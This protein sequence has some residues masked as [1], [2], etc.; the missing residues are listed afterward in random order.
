MKRRCIDE[1]PHAI[2]HAMKEAKQILHRTQHPTNPHSHKA[3][4][5]IMGP[6]GAHCTAQPQLQ[7][8]SGTVLPVRF[9]GFGGGMFDLIPT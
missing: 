3:I 5:C 4:V 9:D 8:A 2:E 1:M 7:G 6:R